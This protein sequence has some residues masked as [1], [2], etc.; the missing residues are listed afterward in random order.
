MNELTSPAAA[1]FDPEQLL[2]T[3]AAVEAIA[4]SP[5]LPEHLRGKRKGGTFTA[6][7]PDTI[8]ANLLL[9][10]D[11]ARVF[12]CN[13][14]MLAKSSFVVGAA[15]D[16][17]GKV[18]A[19]LANMSGFLEEDLDYRL[20]GEGQDRHVVVVG[21]MK[22]E[23]HYREALLHITTALAAGGGS[24]SPEWKTNP[25]QMLCYAGA[26]QWVRRYLSKVMLGFVQID[27]AEM[28]P[29]KVEYVDTRHRG[30]AIERP[31]SQAKIAEI[32]PSEDYKKAIIDL[33]RVE[34][35]HQA[36][37]IAEHAGGRNMM[38]DDERNRILVEARKMWKALPYS[39]DDPENPA[40][41]DTGEATI[42]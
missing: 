31:E 13:M 16:F 17:D 10:A 25:D 33:Q 5:L 20:G 11:A 12:Q 28:E 40:N 3:K 42:A 37:R 39:E 29:T 27:V 21:R 22:G 23:S 1:V 41:L 30:E 38:T 6:Y 26:R 32:V 34:F 14:L 4:S 2:K 7:D 18:Y 8:V 15:L 9:V 35:K 36:Q 24:S 19:A